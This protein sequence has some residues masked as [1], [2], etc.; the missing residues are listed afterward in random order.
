MVF[1]NWIRARVRAAVMAGIADALD[2]LDDGTA[3]EHDGTEAQLQLRLR[4]VQTPTLPAADEDVPAG[5][6]KRA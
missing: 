1:F 4:L 2:T 3:I 6:R 5:K